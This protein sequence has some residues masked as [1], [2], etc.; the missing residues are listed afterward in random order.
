M[1]SDKSIDSNFKNHI[2]QEVSRP[3][4]S[5]YI[6]TTDYVMLKRKSL[7]LSNPYFLPL[8]NENNP[9]SM[10]SWAIFEEYNNRENKHLGEPKRFQGLVFCQPGLY[11]DQPQYL[12]LR[13]DKSFHHL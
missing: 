12:L 9:L 10:T 11:L 5:L 6:L 1:A 3:S 2:G 8:S 7:N 13:K 4:S